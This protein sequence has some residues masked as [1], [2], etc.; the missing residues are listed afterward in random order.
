M[1][2]STFIKQG[3]LPKPDPKAAAQTCGSM[4]PRIYKQMFGEIAPKQPESAA[5]KDK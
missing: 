4:N 3:G 1:S 2:A 5:S